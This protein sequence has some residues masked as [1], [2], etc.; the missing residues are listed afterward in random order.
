MSIRCIRPSPRGETTVFCAVIAGSAV[1]CKVSGVIVCVWGAEPPCHES[2]GVVD[3]RSSSSR[4]E[5]DESSC[6][7][8]AT[9]DGSGCRRA[10]I[11]H[12]GGR[13]PVPSPAGN[14]QVYTPATRIS[15]RYA[16]CVHV[17]AHWRRWCRGRTT[18]SSMRPTASASGI[19]AFG[20]ATGASRESSSGMRSRTSRPL[21]GAQ[22][23]RR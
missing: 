7:S 8:V 17:F 18:E 19:A 16:H 14:A 3:C 13:R 5:S 20:A 22:H 11:G 4:S 1:S 15:W 9:V 23:M 6:Q 10:H 12:G 2:S 21:N